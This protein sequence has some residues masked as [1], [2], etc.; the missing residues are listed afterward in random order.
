MQGNTLGLASYHFESEENCYIS[1]SSPQCQQWPDLEN[2]ERPPAKKQFVNISVDE[3]QRVFKGDI[4]WAPTSWHGDVLWRYKMRFSEDYGTIIGGKVEA[5][6]A[7]ENGNIRDTHVF[8]VN[9]IYKRWLMDEF[10]RMIQ[11]MD[12]LSI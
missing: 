7:V 11:D 1:Y 10:R 3:E 5:F 9:L 12:N 4:V 8:G 6:D 2:G